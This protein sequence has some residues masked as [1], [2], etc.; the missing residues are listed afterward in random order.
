MTNHLAWPQDD[1]TLK[2]NFTNRQD[3]PQTDKTLKNELTNRQ[4]WPGHQRTAGS[5]GA[6]HS[7]PPLPGA[8]A[9]YCNKHN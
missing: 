4:A 5:A 8:R 9:G 7:S 2:T 6:L 1:K 3:W